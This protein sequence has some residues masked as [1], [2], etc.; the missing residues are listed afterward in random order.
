MD[1]QL[2]DKIRR[3]VKLL[4]SA[5]KIAAEHGQPLEICYSGGKDSDVILQ[6]AREAGIDYRAIYKNTTIDPPRTIAHARANGVEIMQPK[7][8]FKEIIEKNGLPSRWRRFCCKYL[9]EYKV[10]DYA[11]IGVRRDESAK[12]AALYK[13]PEMCKAYSKTQKVR[14]YL[15]ILEWSAADVAAFVQDRGIMCHPLYYDA[16][17]QFHPERRLGCMCCPLASRKHRLAEFA[18]YPRILKL[19]LR[20]ARGFLDSHPEAK[21]GNIYPSVYEWLTAHIFCDT[22]E[23]FKT[24]FG[25]TLFDDGIDCKQFLMDFFKVEL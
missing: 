20:G 4:Q 13:E 1:K 3:G 10:L 7:M 23:E 25:A 12:R 18:K 22:N 5:A 9:K 16:G 15:P 19:Y 24:R 2:K 17:G 6:L 11:V 21:I 14:Q 8:S